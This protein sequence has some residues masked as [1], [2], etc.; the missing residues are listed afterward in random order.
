MKRTADCRQ[1]ITSD[2][3]SPDTMLC[4]LSVLCQS[5][6]SYVMLCLT[7]CLAAV[8]LLCN[9][10]SFCLSSSWV[11]NGL[12]C[13]SITV[14]QWYH[15]GYYHLATEERITCLLV[16]RDSQ[17]WQPSHANIDTIYKVLILQKYYTT[18]CNTIIHGARQA[19]ISCIMSWRGCA[20]GC[21]LAACCICL[22]S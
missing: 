7:V 8:Q 20:D 22:F 6:R 11:T 16:T 10:G 3:V 21:L 5:G 12:Q 13:I 14:C 2:R 18:W 15:A 4:H 17:V 1:Y 19:T 9:R